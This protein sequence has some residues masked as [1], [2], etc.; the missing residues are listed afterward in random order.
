[1]II[2]DT[3][4]EG[5]EAMRLVVRKGKHQQRGRSEK[6][7]DTVQAVIDRDLLPMLEPL[8]RF[9][10]EKLT[11]KKRRKKR[12]IWFGWI[13]WLPATMLDL[14]ML[15]SGNFTFYSAFVFAVLAAWVLHPQLQ[16]MKH[17]KEK[18]VPVLLQAFGDFQYSKDGCI[19][20]EAVK[21]FDIMP[22][23]STKTHDDKIQGNID[24]MKFE[25]CEIKLR[26]RNRKSSSTVHKGGAL[27]ISMPFQFA[28]HTVINTDR[29]T[30]G[31][32]LTASMSKSKI[33]LEN[34][35]FEGRYEVYGSDQQYARYLLSPGMM[36]RI[37]KLDDL[38][39]DHA[40]GSKLTCEFRDNRALFMLSY[41]G[42]LLD[43]V[44]INASAYDLGKMPLLEQQLSMITGIIHQLNLDYLSAKNVA[45]GRLSSG[46]R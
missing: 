13:F 31:N 17:Y 33:A 24:G 44:D 32:L 30:A 28:A 26:R 29:G 27:L 15:I 4:L 16:Y 42:D 6:V 38:F 25:F 14:A 39:R 1:V 40:K 23:F 12:F 9:R 7:S 5:L 43:V 10:I 37:I 8:E 46:L 3:L 20:L 21:S 18:L 35:T 19:D 36:D 34:P 2:L 22:K 45:R 11:T 41:A